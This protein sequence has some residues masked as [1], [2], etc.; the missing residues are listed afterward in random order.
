MPHSQARLLVTGASGNLGRLVIQELLK[1]VEAHR[2]IATTRQPEK[3]KDLATLGIEVRKADFDQPETLESAFAGANNVLIISTDAVG[4]RV[5]G[6]QAAIAAAK[7]ANV[8]HILY[9]SLPNAKDT[10]GILAAEHAATEQAMQGSGLNYTFLRHSLYFEVALQNLTGAFA[11]GQLAGAAGTGQTA[12]VSREDCARADAAALISAGSENRQYDIT[13]SEAYSYEQL[14]KILSEVTGRQIGYVDLS[15]A[16]FKKAL[17][18][19]GL[20]E[21]FAQ[22]FAD[23]DRAAKEGRM[24]QVST[25]VKD[26]TGQAPLALP[27]FLQQN[28]AVLMGAK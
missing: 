24:S 15:E 11:R 19:S 16:D 4:S 21:G 5:K 13:G 2:I 12:Y 28:K 7:K 14:A 23:F 8:K 1:T 27:V 9:T 3:L 6:H 25:A 20:P 17:V 10:A 26:L 18:S 22:V